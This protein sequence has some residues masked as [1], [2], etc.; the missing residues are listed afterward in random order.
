MEIL[1]ACQCAIW[2]IQFYLDVSG[3]ILVFY[4]W[5][6]KVHT[7]ETLKDCHCV[8]CKRAQLHSY[9]FIHCIRA[10]VFTCVPGKKDIICSSVQEQILSKTG[11]MQVKLHMCKNRNM[12]VCVCMY[13]CMYACMNVRMYESMNVWQHKHS[14]RIK[15]RDHHIKWHDMTWHDMPRRN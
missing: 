8:S 15:W 9:L 5:Q 7:D 10:S 2:K 6:R 12:H 3:S 11:K 1:T 13:A 14:H 4:Q